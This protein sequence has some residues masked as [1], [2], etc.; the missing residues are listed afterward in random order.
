MTRTPHTAL[1][2]DDDPL[3]RLDACG[4]LED[5][6]FIAL[7]ATDAAA[8][9]EILTCGHDDLTLLFTD[10]QMPGQ[11]DG[12]ELARLTH[13]SWP[14]IGILVTSG[15]ARPRAGDLPPGARFIAKPFSATTV[16][17]HLLDILPPDRAPEPLK[18]RAGGWR[19]ATTA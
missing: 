13:R 19:S 12:L 1:V 17:D 5:A 6:G 8:A 2:V 14:H 18:E 4:I 7:G 9:V 15:A 3:I 10:V 11:R 16:Y